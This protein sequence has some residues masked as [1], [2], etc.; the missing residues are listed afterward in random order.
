MG[1]AR[2]PL[3]VTAAQ[4]DKTLD[5][6]RFSYISDDTYTAEEVEEHTLVGLQAGRVQSP[7]CGAWRAA[8]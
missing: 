1:D 7:S 8:G 3:S 6:Q 5:P 4:Q 2:R